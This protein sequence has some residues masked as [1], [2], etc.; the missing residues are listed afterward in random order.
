MPYLLNLEKWQ[1]DYEVMVM[2]GIHSHRDQEFN[3]EDFY[4]FDYKPPFIVTVY[5][6]DIDKGEENPH[7]HITKGYVDAPTFHCCVRL[8]TNKYYRNHGANDTLSEEDVKA[9]KRYMEQRKKLG[10]YQGEFTAWECAASAW[11]YVTHDPVTGDY[12][13]HFPTNKIP[14]PD[15]SVILEE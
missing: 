6:D 3:S 8:D 2:G 12:D 10:I 1:F 15:Y 5:A 7:C 14:M 4:P 9:F 11:C 13:V